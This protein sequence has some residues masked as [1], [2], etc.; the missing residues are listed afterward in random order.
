MADQIEAGDWVQVVGCCC[1][2]SERWLGLVFKAHAFP[3]PVVSRSD[4][5]KTFIAP[6][7]NDGTAAGGWPREH[8]KRLP[9]LDE[10]AET[11][12]TETHKEPA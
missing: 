3:G 8:L 10:P 11:Y 6:F 9:G 5:G 12:T 1:I 7:F 2:R 4:C